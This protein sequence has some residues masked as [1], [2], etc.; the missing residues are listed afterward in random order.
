MNTYGR[1]LAIG[2]LLTTAAATSLPAAADD[3]VIADFGGLIQ[4]MT[5]EIYI[6]TFAADEKVNV[7][8][9]T[10]DYGIG[11]VKAKIDGGSNIWDVVAIEDLEAMQGCE[12]GWLEEIDWSKI[13]SKS[14]LLPS[15]VQDCAI[16]KIVYNIVLTYSSTR[17]PDGPKSWADFWDTA[18]WP[19]KR[20]MEKNPRG[21]LE[22]ALLADGVAPADVYKE[23]S[24][25]AG[26]DRAFAKLDELKPNI[27]WWAHPGQAREMIKSG[28]SVMGTSYDSGNNYVNMSENAGLQSVWKNP[29]I[30]T[31]YWGIVAGAKNK[32]TALRF[33]NY[34]TNAERQ[35]ELASKMGI[36]IV[37][38]AAFP[39]IDS[40]VL[41][42]LPTNP[43]NIK[44]GLQ[45]DPEFWLDNFDELNRRFAAWAGQ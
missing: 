14:T 13:E 20:S 7:T 45:S 2:T 27:I 38:T 36:G 16:G 26:V 6:K 42:V 31:D 28:E 10:R 40:K 41:A 43:E 18:K 15:A 24:T 34:A 19:G 9:D 37:N 17:T 21:Q 22:I 1:L 29:I 23:L 39:H 32:E 4:K 33:I 12:E 3:L 44:D 11:V 35:A 30:A 8:E 25:P 5:S